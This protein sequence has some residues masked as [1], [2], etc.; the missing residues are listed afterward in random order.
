MEYRW[1]KHPKSLIF[2]IVMFT[3][4]FIVACGSSAPPDA[5]GTDAAKPADTQPTAAS[6]AMSQPTMNS[7][8]NTLA[9]SGM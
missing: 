3:L 7:S 8:G 4:L 6:E 1:L 2:T 5:S 9:N